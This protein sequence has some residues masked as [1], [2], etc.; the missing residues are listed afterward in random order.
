VERGQNTLSNQ[1]SLLAWVQK[2]ANRAAQLRSSV[3]TNSNFSG[4][5]PQAVNKAASAMN[6]AISRMQPQG[7]ELQIWVDQ[8]PFNDVLAW[9]QA[10]ESAGIQI[11]DLDMIQTDVPGQVKIRRL[12]LAKS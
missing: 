9:L 5:L 4:A 7:Q 2:N 3:T 1:R 6:I 11:I 8:A 12:K 10:L